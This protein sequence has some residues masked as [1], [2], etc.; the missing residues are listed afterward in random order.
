[1]EIFIFSCILLLVSIGILVTYKKSK[2]ILHN[3]IRIGDYDFDFYGGVNLK[4]DETKCTRCP[5]GRT[6]LC[7]DNLPDP[8]DIYNKNSRFSIF[9][10]SPSSQIGTPIQEHDRSIIDRYIPTS[11]SVRKFREDYRIRVEIERRLEKYKYIICGGSVFKF[12]KGD[13]SSCA[14]DKNREDPRF[15]GYNKKIWTIISNPDTHTISRI[16]IPNNDHKNQFP[17]ICMFC[18]CPELGVKKDTKEI[19]RVYRQGKN[20]PN[21]LQIL[22]EGQAFI[23]VLKHDELF[24]INVY[25]DRGNNQFLY[26]SELLTYNKYYEFPVS[27]YVTDK[28][29]WCVE[30]G[31]R[32]LMVNK[33]S[34]IIYTTR[35]IFSCSG[36]VIK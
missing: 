31:N 13:C 30:N 23:V 28:G 2:S 9:C 4:E 20:N 29:F 15:P 17:N 14:L 8:R 22:E 6:H 34:T 1:M 36:K 35:G 3:I 12:G 24:E 11:E 33:G 16:L 19:L 5:L 18:K 10:I 21:P 32:K 25:D 7:D 26:D 27:M